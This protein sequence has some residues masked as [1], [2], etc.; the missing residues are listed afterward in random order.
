MEQPGHFAVPR[1]LH[2]SVESCGGK[3]DQ[4]Y[5]LDANETVKKKTEVEDRRR[6]LISVVSK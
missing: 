6:Q 1:F 4:Q 5:R 2:F 3:P